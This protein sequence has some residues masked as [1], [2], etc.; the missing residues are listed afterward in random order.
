MI[1]DHISEPANF[2]HCDNIAKELKQYSCISGRFDLV[3]SLAQGGVA[4]HLKE[5]VEPEEIINNWPKD[6]FGGSAEPHRTRRYN[7]N[8]KVS[9]YLRD[10]PPSI[11]I[12]AIKKALSEIP[13]KS[14]RRLRYFDT[15]KPMPIIKVDFQCANDYKK[16]QVGKDQEKAQ[17]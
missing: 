14:L 16:V 3:Y 12:Q 8:K 5:G 15:K 7:Q 11:S 13:Y 17:S 4:L 10:I 9:A 2:R 1:V 6:I